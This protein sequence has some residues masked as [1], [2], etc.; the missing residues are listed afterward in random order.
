[1]QRAHVAANQLPSF[2]LWA[3]SKAVMEIRGLNRKKGSELQL[4]EFTNELPPGPR[5]FVLADH[6]R[7]K[8]M[9]GL[10]VIYLV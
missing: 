2:E 3:L 4:E 7:L 8:P 9:K 10:N 1:M 6:E 5:F